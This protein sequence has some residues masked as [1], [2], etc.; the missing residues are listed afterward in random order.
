MQVQRSL[1]KAMK[2]PQ[3]VEGLDLRQV[4]PVL[5]FPEIEQFINLEFIDISNCPDLD[6][7]DACIKLS[8]LP[9]LTEVKAFGANISRLPEEFGLL[10]HLKKIDFASNTA[11]IKLPESFSNLIALEDISFYGC[12]LE[13]LEVWNFPNL[14]TLSLGRN[15]LKNFPDQF[16]T[17]L[18]ALQALT[19]SD[20]QLESFP[21]SICDLKDLRTMLA[22]GNLL[23]ELPKN[24]ARLTTL[25][26]LWLDSCS[27]INFEHE[28]EKIKNIPIRNLSI[29]GNNISTIP[30]VFKDIQ[31]LE[32]LN[33]NSNKLDDTVQLV[34]DLSHL[35]LKELDIRFMGT[36][37][38]SLSEAQSTI[39]TLQQI[40]CDTRTKEEYGKDILHWVSNQLE[41]A[42]K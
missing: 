8:K 3:S 20:N 29:L 23:Q 2:D 1:K 4:K 12:G 34:K 17:G 18:P 33:I 41:L 16:F 39:P 40:A 5:L 30:G 21:E 15:K 24:F 7:K 37:D 10:K 9:R 22:G 32:I 11:L 25:E 35:P 26:T 36:K 13:I 6:W 14:R 19:A 31:S 38:I 28:L 42:Q 27:A